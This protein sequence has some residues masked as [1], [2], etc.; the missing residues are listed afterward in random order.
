MEHSRIQGL[1]AF[2]GE[3]LGL[4]IGAIGLIWQS[5]ARRA[6]ITESG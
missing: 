4:W 1:I 2:Y 6:T 3:R 5:V